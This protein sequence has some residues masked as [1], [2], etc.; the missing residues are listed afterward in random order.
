MHWHINTR[1][2]DLW[3]FALTMPHIR[4]VSCVR[5]CLIRQMGNYVHVFKLGHIRTGG[6]V[7][8]GNAVY[9]KRRA[10]L[11]Y[12]LNNRGWELRNTPLTQVKFSTTYNRIGWLSTTSKHC[13]QII[14]R[15]GLQFMN[16]IKERLW[17]QVWATKTTHLL[18]SSGLNQRLNHKMRRESWKSC[19]LM[20]CSMKN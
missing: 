19:L 17:R 18:P 1:S 9:S 7:T 2:S 13:L 16:T 6:E 8:H 3:H 20:K 5:R 4:A 15:S 10:L 12:I 11:I 14:I